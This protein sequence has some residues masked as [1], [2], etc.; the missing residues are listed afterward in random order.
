MAFDLSSFFGKYTSVS[1]GSNQVQAAGNV[2][3]NNS[4]MA[5]KML[6]LLPGQT[7]QGEIVSMQGSQVQLLLGNEFLLNASLDSQADMNI[8]QLMSFQVRSISNSLISLVPLSVNLTMDENVMKA[9][10]E[11]G[12]PVTDR[13]VEM[14][15]TLMKEGMPIDKET[16][17][18][19]NKELLAFP[20][21]GTETLVQ[22]TRLKIPITEANLEQFEAYKNYNHKLSDGVTELQN[23]WNSLLQIAG[24]GAA[25]G[26]ES[27][28]EFLRQMLSFLADGEESALQ[29]EDGSVR[30]ITGTEGEMTTETEVET[31][32]GIIEQ[33]KETIPVPGKE[34]SEQTTA[35]EALQD[36][37]AS[38]T[39]MAE[40]GIGEG[41]EK[42][43]LNAAEKET[44]LSLLREIGADSKTIQAFQNGQLNGKQL[45]ALL[46]T[47]H[48]G[49]EQ[50]AKLFS[51][52][53]FGKLLQ[54]EMVN[55][56]LLRPEQVNKEEVEE[57][58]TNFKNQTSK[59]MQLLESTGRGDSPAAKTLQNMNRNVDFLNQ[60]NQMYSYVQL[61]LKMTRDTA[62]GDLYVY[63]NKKNLAKKDGNVSALLHLDMPHLGML[64]VYVAMQEERVST[65]F[66]L[67]DESVMD[68]LEQHMEL[69][70][71]RLEQKGYQ[72]SA[73]VVLREQTEEK[74]T[75]MEEILKQEKNVPEMMKIGMRSFDVRA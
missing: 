49:G 34:G 4:A 19:M 10:G 56:F 51:S 23:H 62:H 6:A 25:E 32:A 36:G 3:I 28:Q 42:E 5:S 57:Y 26:L 16:L 24:K 15:N 17:L 55:Q 27:S 61:P 69:L 31:K 60:L 48:L 72:T 43:V 7:V 41:S 44:F 47:Q 22:M 64:D 45:A 52:K 58:Y 37:K 73:Q 70:T 50:L 46:Q 74:T 30:K 14:V 38:L 54:N 75:V 35:K 9:L 67:Q 8:G 2:Q 39:Q 21:A 12:L 18:N 1:T 33:G 68:F 53:E 29:N 11:A 59:L 65:K 71:K 63:T 40:V 66:Y 13:T 20:K